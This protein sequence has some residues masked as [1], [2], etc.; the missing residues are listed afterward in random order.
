MATDVISEERGGGDGTNLTPLL[1]ADVWHIAT[2]SSVSAADATKAIAPTP[3][4]A[5]RCSRA[6]LSALAGDSILGRPRFARRPS[7]WKRRWQRPHN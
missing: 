4:P 7:A 6:P 5:A 3:K 2:L 1:V